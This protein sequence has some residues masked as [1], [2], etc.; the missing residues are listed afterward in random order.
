MNST[1]WL[2]Q[3]RYRRTVVTDLQDQGQIALAIAD[4]RL[5]VLCVL[6]TI[7]RRCERDPG[8]PFID[9][10]LSLMT[11]EDYAAD[12]PSRGRGTIFG[13]IQG[14]GL[15]ALAGHDAWI[16]GQA[17]LDVA[18][19][20]EFHRRIVQVLSRAVAHMEEIRA[21]NGGHLFFMM[22]RD[23]VPLDIAEGGRL[24]PMRQA[25]GPSG[26]ASSGE[27]GSVPSTMSDL[28]YCKGL[29][30]AATCLR[31]SAAIASAR[32]LYARVY[33]DIQAGRFRNDQQSFDPRNPAGEVPGRH[34]HA[35]RMIAIGAASRF[36][37]CTGDPMY[38]SRGLEYIDYI[39]ARHVNVD[40]DGP[41]GRQYDMWEFTDEAGKPYVEAGGVVRSDPGHATEFVGL[42]LKLL[43]LAETTGIA[44]TAADQE[45]VARAR[46]TLPHVL[47]Q[48]FTNGCSSQGYGLAKAYDVA[49]HRV[50][51]DQ[52]PWW[53]LPET[54]R[55]AIE[56]LALYRDDT[57]KRRPFEQIVA[58]CSNAFARYFVRPDLHLM[59]YQTI[60][61]DG[62]PVDAIPATPDADPAYHTGL[63]LID[64]LDV[65][66]D[67]F[68]CP[69]GR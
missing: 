15:E 11:G 49:A 58:A 25:G 24:A 39:L 12:D 68:G 67:T 22:N 19:R 52:M 44:L 51:N 59:A 23:G 43:R 21:A 29:M 46:A 32:A 50:L 17:D 54:M 7:L 57:A 14:R 55:G 16:A 53:S 18:L 63:S 2:D 4:Y 3:A 64:G 45:R 35:G 6:D 36:L 33:E 20:E 8:Y 10:K 1:D 27:D 9:T 42:S 41:A 37:A 69:A 34:S 38:A 61:P 66:R 62:R 5:M 30:A 13:W 47:R 26:I 31:D 56:C 28:F 40:G 60:G 48:N 65:L